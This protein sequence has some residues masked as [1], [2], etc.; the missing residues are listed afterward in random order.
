[1]IWPQSCSATHFQEVS[2]NANAGV[3][4]A[5]GRYE[6]T[7][8][9][10]ACNSKTDNQYP[11]TPCMEPEDPKNA[12]FCLDPL[13]S[14]VSVFRFFFRADEFTDPGF[15]QAQL[16]MVDFQLDLVQQ[17]DEEIR[18]IVETIAELAQIMRDLSTLVVDQGTIL[19]RIDY[20]LVQ[21][22]EKV[23]TEVSMLCMSVHIRVVRVLN[24][25]GGA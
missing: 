4:I 18:T 21:T 16:G 5:S 12:K 9:N 15:T 11:Q 13:L 8:T 7:N 22:L 20:N 2:A 3:L 6:Q 24:R 10:L 23:R 19:D 25:L 17:R 14:P 1:M